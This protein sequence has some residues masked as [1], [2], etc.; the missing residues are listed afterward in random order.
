MQQFWERFLVGRS[1]RQTIAKHARGMDRYVGVLTL[2]TAALLGLGSAAPFATVQNFYGLNGQF[3]LLTAALELFKAGDTVYA[4]GIAI[5]FAVIPVFSIATVF[6]L[7]YKYALHEEKT[8]RIIARAKL[9][10][11]L[12]FFVMLATISLVY[13]TQTSS[14]DAVLHPPVYYLV[15]SV[16]IQKLILSRVSRLLASVQY[17][18]E[19]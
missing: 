6:D 11:R 3:S 12:W 14:A 8:E 2:F 18:E 1:D 7:W 15:V 4:A 19:S 10:G 17:V 13:Y 16:L 5:L 9:C